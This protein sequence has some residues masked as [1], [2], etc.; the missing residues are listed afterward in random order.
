MGR[1]YPDE[2]RERRRA[3]RAER[4]RVRDEVQIEV[5]E[6]CRPSV[7]PPPT[8]ERKGLVIHFNGEPGP[9]LLPPIMTRPQD[10]ALPAR[11]YLWGPEVANAVE[12]QL[13]SHS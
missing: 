10:W 1:H 6:Q 9:G 4:A 5:A 2:I 12:Q 11:T 3:K 13:R 7:S 8:V